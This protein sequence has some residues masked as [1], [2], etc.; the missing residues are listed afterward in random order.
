[1]PNTCVTR[2][3]DSIK[4]S[5]SRIRIAP[6]LSPTSKKRPVIM[7]SIFRRRR[8]TISEFIRNAIGK[9]L[10]RK[11]LRP[12][13]ARLEVVNNM[14]TNEDFTKGY[15]REEREE[16]IAAVHHLSRKTQKNYLLRP[17]SLIEALAGP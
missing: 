4:S 5:T 7:A 11:A 17:K 2:L 13:S 3:P 16:Q 6:W 14:A 12:G 15:S 10:P 1:M 8:G 9:R